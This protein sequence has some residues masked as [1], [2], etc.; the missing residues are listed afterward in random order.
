MEETEHGRK[1]L[2]GWGWI[3]VILISALII[4]WGLLNFVLV[5]DPP[6]TWHFGTLPDTPSQ[7][8]YSTEAPPAVTGNPPQQIPPLPEAQPKK[9]AGGAP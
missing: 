4:G 6:R 9:K 8:I 7:S 3:V 1:A 5:R 2:P